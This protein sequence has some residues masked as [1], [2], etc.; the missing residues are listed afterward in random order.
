MG[1]MWLKKAETRVYSVKHFNESILTLVATSKN[2][3]DH[4]SLFLK[5]SRPLV[6]VS[7]TVITVLHSAEVV[8]FHHEP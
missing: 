7:S 2:I 1:F 5:E 6:S 4:I 8:H 3:D